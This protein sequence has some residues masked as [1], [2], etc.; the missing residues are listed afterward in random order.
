ML[1]VAITPLHI[2][3]ADSRISSIPSILFSDNFDDG[4]ADGWI[5]SGLGTWYIENG[6]YSVDMG[7]GGFLGG[8]STI[9][10]LSWTDYIYDV[11]VR[12]ESGI[13][14]IVIFRYKDDSNNYHV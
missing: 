7:T 2:V 5:V 13:D 14:K 12:G 3:S 9:G 1:L 11:D 10:D 8:N 6:E 4:N